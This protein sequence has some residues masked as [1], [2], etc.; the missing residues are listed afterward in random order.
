MDSMYK[1]LDV[2]KNILH[3]REENYGC[4]A[5]SL[6]E[7]AEMWGDYLQCPVQPQDVAALMIMLKLQRAKDNGDYIDN[8]IDIAGYAAMAGGY[9]V[10]K[11]GTQHHDEDQQNTEHD[12]ED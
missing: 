7:T 11:Q 1:L 6:Q 4:P 3:D 2:T 5:C 9:S 10:A 12:L 8:W